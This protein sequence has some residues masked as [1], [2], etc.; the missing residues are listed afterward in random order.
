MHNPAADPEQLIRREFDTCGSR[1]QPR[2]VFGL[3]GERP[4][5]S[6]SALRQA[7]AHGLQ[8]LMSTA[9]SPAS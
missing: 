7:V 8:I 2:H 6:E 3:D 5:V 9:P 4:A 1:Q